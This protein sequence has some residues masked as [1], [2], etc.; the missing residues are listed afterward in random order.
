MMLVLL[1]LLSWVVDYFVL[2]LPVS[3]PLFRQFTI[4]IIKQFCLMDVKL[5]LVSK[6]LKYRPE[7]K[8]GP[9]SAPNRPL[10]KPCA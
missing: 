9:Q 10:S 3:C 4:G 6:A 5:I 2:V 7:I 8:I 1:Y